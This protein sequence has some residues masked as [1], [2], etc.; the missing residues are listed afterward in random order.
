MTNLSSYRTRIPFGLVWLAW[1]G[2]SP[3][4]AMEP[5]AQKPPSA[6][7]AAPAP[8]QPSLAQFQAALLALLSAASD[9]GN[10][11]EVIQGLMNALADG[12][13]VVPAPGPLASHTC[14]ACH[15]VFAYHAGVAPQ[16]ACP[17]CDAAV[18]VPQGG[19]GG[20]GPAEEPGPEP[21]Q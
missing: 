10:Q 20:E 7:A 19:P 3:L 18:D 15:L 5:N 17:A 2:L 21:E 4:A 14:P 12:S 13:L 8:E 11:A 1:A 9:H 6:P 16:V